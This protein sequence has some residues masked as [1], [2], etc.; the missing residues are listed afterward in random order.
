MHRVATF[1]SLAAIVVLAF[2]I[3]AP[4]L[5]PNSCMELMWNNVAYGISYSAVC[6]GM[7]LLLSVFAFSY[8]AIWRVPWSTP[9][10]WWHLA[11]SVAVATG[12]LAC[13]V[14]NGLWHEQPERSLPLT[15]TLILSPS[16]FVLI[17]VGFGM[18][19]LRRCLL[20]VWL[21]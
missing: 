8:A 6:F 14:I 21:H 12:F 2:G 15:A 19:A 3:A 16:I 18:D 20:L 13:L 7:G 11:L 9:A 1:F 4:R 10:G 5:V 17:Q